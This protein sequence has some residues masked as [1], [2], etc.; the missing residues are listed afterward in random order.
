[1]HEKCAG[2]SPKLCGSIIDPNRL[3]NETDI[4]RGGVLF[5]E[6][7]NLPKPVIALLAFSLISGVFCVVIGSLVRVRF[8]SPLTQFDATYDLN[9]NISFYLP[10][11]SREA[12]K[13]VFN[14]IFVKPCVSVFNRVHGSATKWQVA[15]END[16]QTERFP[17]DD[18]RYCPNTRLEFSSNPRFLV[19][20]DS[21]LGPTGLPANV[22][23]SVCLAITY[24]AS[25]MVLLEMEDIGEELGKSVPNT[26]LSHFALHVLGGVILIQAS[27]SIWALLRTDIKTWNQT[28]FATAYIL[29]QEMGRI[30]K[31]PGRCMQ[32]LYHRFR[33]S[34]GVVKPENIQVSAWD[35]HPIFRILMMR[36]WVMIG[37]GFYWGILMFSVVESGS[38][39][40][41]RRKG[42]LP[43][44]EPANST[45]STG[46][47]VFTL[48]WNGVAPSFGLL[49]GIAVIVGFQGGIITT[50][51]TCAQ[52]ILD[53]VCDQ[54]L[55]R[56][57]YDVN[58]SDPKPHMFKKF[59][60]CWHSYLIHL[61]DPF[62]HWGFGLAVGISADKGLQILPVPIFWVSVAGVAGAIYMTCYLKMKIKTS[63][64]ATFGHLQTMV[65]LIDEWHEKMYWGDKSIGYQQG[66]AGTSGSPYCVV[67]I[68]ES[69][70]YGGQDCAVCHRSL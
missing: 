33:D 58:G 10:P 68:M 43:I 61:A 1:M 28:P 67:K 38:P 36:I 57:I 62:F 4:E 26:V 19:S 3:E 63:L 47:N 9:Y 27:I 16:L 13:L 50:A 14:V 18:P 37:I 32:S 7:R 55:W 12:I 2:G 54:R 11:Y 69:K 20:S 49:W 23:M 70:T 25:Q 22:V 35:T 48:G 45:S 53:L 39:G 30:R 15:C 40:T 31:T 42:W 60:V 41:F 66:H 46:T 17:R 34:Q 64:P 24:A 6:G 51:M 5:A 59:V 56:E 65:D 52:T 29:S 8:F 21:I 44:A